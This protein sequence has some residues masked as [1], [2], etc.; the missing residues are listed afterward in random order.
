MMN[1]PIVD[2][3]RKNRRALARKAKFNLKT[4]AAQAQKRQKASGHKV[5]SFQKNR[6]L[7]T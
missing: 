1:D 2:E 4:I 5:V 3:I 6:P 7:N